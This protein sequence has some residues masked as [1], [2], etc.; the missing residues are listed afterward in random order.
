MSVFF[1]MNKT[2][3]HEEYDTN[4][5]RHYEKYEYDTTCIRHCKKELKD[6]QD[7]LVV[8]VFF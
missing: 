1:W 5:I 4:L 8:S 6:E 3:I 7:T 2:L